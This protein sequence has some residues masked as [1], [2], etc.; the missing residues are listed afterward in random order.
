MPSPLVTDSSAGVRLI[1]LNRAEKKNAFDD[2]QWDGFADALR[3]ANADEDVAVA[4]VTGAGGDFSAG[5]DL[6]SFAGGAKPRTGPFASGYDNTMDALVAFEKPL[7]AAARGVCVGF[8]AT[9][10][11]HCDCV[12]LGESARLRLP[13][14]RLGLVPEGA[15]SYLLQALIGPRRAGEL[16]YTAE[17]IPAARALEVGIA[18]SLHADDA[19]LGVALAKAREMAQFPVSAL[20]ESKRTLKAALAPGIAVALEAERAGMKAQAGS[21]ENVEAVRAFME[22]REPDYRAA[23][24]RARAGKPS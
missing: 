6:S 8:G 15:S 2:A 9:F 4:V 12:Y 11:F 23:R 17:W 3:A 20:R 21:A 1:T 7:L 22:K 5:V 24:A 10:L 18:T 14:V 13:F 16:M 19:V